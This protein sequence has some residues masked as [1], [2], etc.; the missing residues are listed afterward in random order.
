MQ[1]WTLNV[2]KYS[3]KIY[4]NAEGTGLGWAGCSSIPCA[5]HV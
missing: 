5:L 1:D 4:I 3:T 2:D